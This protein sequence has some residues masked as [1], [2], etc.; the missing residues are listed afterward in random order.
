MEGQAS[1]ERNQKDEL[2]RG[3]FMLLFLVATRLVGVL[4]F[5]LALFQF[6]C[7]LIVREPNGNVRSFGKGLSRYLAEIVQFLTYNTERKPWPFSPWSDLR[8]TEP[9]GTEAWDR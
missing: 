8:P 6:L 4:L 7:A 2:I 5:F 9:E 3:A 1:F